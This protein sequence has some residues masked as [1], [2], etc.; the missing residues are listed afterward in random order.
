MYFHA[1]KIEQTTGRNVQ[2]MTFIGGIIDLK[3]LM[4]NLTLTI[5]KF[6]GYSE[7]KIW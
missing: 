1:T 4:M 3:Q 6:Y 5:D 7:T 2:K